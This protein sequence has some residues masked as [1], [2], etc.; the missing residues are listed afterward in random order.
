MKI[1]TLSSREFNHNPSKARKGSID[2]PVFITDRGTPIQVIL[3]IDEYRKLTKTEKTLADIFSPTR[4]LA[5][6]ECEPEK[7]IWHDRDIG[8]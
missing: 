1:T 6:L 4:E 8:L 2:G 3:D 5:A 7:I